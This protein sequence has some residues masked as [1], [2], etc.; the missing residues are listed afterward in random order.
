MSSI[1]QQ[2]PYLRVQRNFPMD[3]PQAL[4]VEV[5]RAYCDTATKVNA[6]TIGIFAVNKPIVTGERWFFDALAGEQT[7]NS[8]Q[9][10]TLRQL[11]TFTAAGNIP[12]GLNT[13]GIFRFSRIYG[14]FTDG[15]TSYPLPYVD[16]VS[17]TNQV[18]VVVNATN[19]VITAGAGAPPTISSGFV[20]LEWLS[21]V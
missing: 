11:Y 21:F 7:A 17:A 19:I 3:N 14:T 4:S 8:Q 1:I 13:T 6:R 12:H 15:T 16:V 2:S 20:V 9:Q 5:D 18:N 10:Q